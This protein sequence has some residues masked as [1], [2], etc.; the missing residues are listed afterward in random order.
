HPPGGG[1]GCAIASCTTSLSFLCNPFK[2]RFL[3]SL[4]GLDPKADA[5]VGI[6][7]GPTKLF[8]GKFQENAKVFAFLDINQPEEG[9]KEGKKGITTGIRR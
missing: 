6:P 5:K 9:E 4:T 8:R 1:K 3:V 2:E 7:C